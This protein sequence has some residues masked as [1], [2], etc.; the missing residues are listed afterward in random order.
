MSVFL[1]PGAS[2]WMLA[3]V[4][5]GVLVGILEAVVRQ[6][7]QV[8]LAHRTARDL[9]LAR[10]RIKHRRRPGT[11]LSRVL[12]EHTRAI[13]SLQFPRGHGLTAS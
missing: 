2:I 12:E 4:V 5:L 10:C 11:K 9:A 7:I 13:F 6:R 8:L 3:R 1:L